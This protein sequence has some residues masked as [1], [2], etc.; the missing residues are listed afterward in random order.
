MSLVSYLNELRD[1]ADAFLPDNVNVY[2]HIGRFGANEISRY[3]I[4]CPALVLAVAG[5]ENVVRVGGAYRAPMTV[6][7]FCI[8]KEITTEDRGSMALTVADVFMEYLLFGTLP[9]DGST[10]SDIDLENGYSEQ[11][12]KFGL[13]LFAVT[14]KQQVQVDRRVSWEEL[15]DFLLFRGTYDL[16]DSIDGDDET[17]DHVGEQVLP[18]T[19]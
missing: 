18:A 11:L 12:D 1:N 15:D 2:L 7:A 17:V 19:E 13:A 5:A 6:T 9:E 3:A 8:G 4:R 16:P 14:F 10:P